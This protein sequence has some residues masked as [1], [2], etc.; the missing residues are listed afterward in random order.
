MLD[1]F[2]WGVMLVDTLSRVGDALLFRPFSVLFSTFENIALYNRIIGRVSL[3]SPDIF[4]ALAEVFDFTVG[5][6]LF[7]SLLGFI[8]G[9]KVLKFFLKW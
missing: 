4:R 7:T 2:E 9:V 8:V 6:L 5:E 3:I 1:F